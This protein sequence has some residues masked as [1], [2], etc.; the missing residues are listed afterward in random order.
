MK[1]LII[2]TLFVLLVVSS[3]VATETVVLSGTTSTPI[4]KTGGNYSPQV[5]LV[6]IFADGEYVGTRTGIV[7]NGQVTVNVDGVE[8]PVNPGGTVIRYT[9]TLTDSGIRIECMGNVIYP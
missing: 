1:K 8:V 9:V 3:L 5:V 2:C 7:Q 6:D 4:P